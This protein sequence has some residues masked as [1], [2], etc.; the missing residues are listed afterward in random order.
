[1]Q[2][3]LSVP[4]YSFRAPLMDVMIDARS[5]IGHRLDVPGRRASVRMARGGV[6]ARQIGPVDRYGLVL[7]GCAPHSS[8]YSGSARQLAARSCAGK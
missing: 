6:Q 3:S 4:E 2:L 7:R 8:Y 5:A 1:M